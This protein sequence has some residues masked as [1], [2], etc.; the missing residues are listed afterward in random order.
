MN[1][2][3]DDILSFC[4]DRIKENRL[5]AFARFLPYLRR[6]NPLFHFFDES[7]L[8]KTIRMRRTYFL[9]SLLLLV[10]P[11]LWGQDKAL[12]QQ[13]QIN[14][15]SV[16]WRHPALATFTL[17]NRGRHS[18]RIRRVEPGCDCVAAEWTHEP[19]RPGGKGVVNI[20]YNA[21]LLG[22]FFRDVAVWIGDG[23]EP[24]YLALQGEVVL[25]GGEDLTL[26]PFHVD[27]VWLST[28]DVTF[29]DMR[30]GESRQVVVGILNR[31]AK[32]Y[33]P[34]LMHLPPYLKATAQ[35]ETIRG[36]R[37]GKMILTL[38]STRIKDPGLIQTNVYVSR[39]PGDRVGKDNEL[40]V[41][42][43]VLPPQSGEPLSEDAA[44]PR[45]RIDK[46]TLYF[47]PEA[48]T[49]K[50]KGAF[51]IS[52]VGNRQL[53]IRSLQVLG[54]GVE[55]NVKRQLQPQETAKLDVALLTR[56][57]QGRKS[58]IRLLLIT[59]D[60]QKPVVTLCVRVGP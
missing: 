9:F 32:P 5:L 25:S 10:Q 12:F 27:D 44:A 48:K 28:E 23:K 30:Q 21:S 8:Y 52:N 39:F 33:K 17:H 58:A 20:T 46:D 1:F 14:V 29:S 26:Y 24:V 57:V 37:S 40:S 38:N 51:L 18:V 4:E 60:P 50:L 31:S 13:T 55:V 7:V 35:P 45:C 34:E 16:S 19:I 54:Q 53:E 43:I 41:S 2:S 15:G 59:N 22:H 3:I 49:K 6:K 47:S 36:G 11:F 42:A 56:M